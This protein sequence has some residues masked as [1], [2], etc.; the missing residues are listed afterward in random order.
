MNN[1]TQSGIIRPQYSN[2][3]DETIVGNKPKHWYL[4]H[5]L[6][7]SLKDDTVKDTGNGNDE[8]AAV[9]TEAKVTCKV[10]KKPASA[11]DYAFYF[12]REYWWAVAIASFLLGMWYKKKGA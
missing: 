12:A 8:P 9:V 2:A 6:D 7:G 11:V 5:N 10:E 1:Y 4:T 3:E